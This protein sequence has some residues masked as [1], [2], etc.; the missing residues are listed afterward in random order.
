ML[1]S[2]PDFFTSQL[3]CKEFVDIDLGEGSSCSTGQY[4]TEI[5][6]YLREAE[7]C[8]WRVGCIYGIF[9]RK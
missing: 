2:S 4:A 1:V 5:F 6:T 8:E 9:P 7:V 3:K